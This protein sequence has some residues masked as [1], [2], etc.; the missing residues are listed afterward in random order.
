M[1]PRHVPFA[2][3]A[4]ISLLF[5]LVTLCLS[6][7]ASWTALLHAHMHVGAHCVCSQTFSF[8]V[9]CPFSVPVPAPSPISVPVPVSSLYNVEDSSQ[10][11]NTNCDTPAFFC[12]LPARLNLAQSAELT[13]MLHVKSSIC[14]WC[15]A[16]WSCIL[17]NLKASPETPFLL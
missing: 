16:Y 4:S 10:Q 13:K 2:C 1:T 11:R 15:S 8:P 9:P 17:L 14:R 3:V 6:A 5:L 12:P 7:H